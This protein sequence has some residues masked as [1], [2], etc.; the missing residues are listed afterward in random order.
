M[1]CFSKMRRKA[2]PILDIALTT[3]D[4]N[5]K[6]PVP[7]CGF[8]HH[9]A[10]AYIGKL[11]DS[12]LKVAI[13]EQV[14]DPKKAKGIVAREVVRVVT[15]GLR[16]E[17]DGLLPREQNILLAIS[18]RK[19]AWAVSWLDA[20]TGDFFTS[21]C[22]NM[23]EVASEVDRFKPKEILVPEQEVPMELQVWQKEYQALCPEVRFESVHSQG[24]TLAF[25]KLCR[26]YEVNSLEGFGLQEDHPGVE[27]AYLLLFYAEQKNHADLG[28]LK[29]LLPQ[30]RSEFMSMNSAT[31]SHLELFS[32]LNRFGS[33][34]SLFAILDRCVSAMGSR[35]LKR[36][37]HY[38]LKNVTRIEE[39]LQVVE[40][41]FRKGRR[42][43]LYA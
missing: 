29:A 30:Q 18:W 13:C 27:G 20:S 26:R 19:N 21:P 4:K 10:E 41:F 25:E 11:L 35:L 37:M 1:K 16:T 3:R 7:L 23:E 36:W 40:F 17:Q 6:Q 34:R 8:P 2:A 39:R 31:R 24:N 9:S 32:G 28:H 22:K 42:S 14:E 33:Q 43:F 5:A 12:G 38:P 15:P